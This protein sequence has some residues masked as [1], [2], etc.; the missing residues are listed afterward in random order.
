MIRHVLFDLDNTLYSAS[1]GLDDFYFQRVWE[2]AASWLKL[3]PEEVKQIWTEGYTR[4]GTTIGW[5]KSERGFNDIEEYYAWVH[6]EHE[7]DCLL[8]DP[9]LRAFLESLPYPS[10][11][12]TNS[13]RFHADRILKKLELEGVFCQII[14]IEDTGYYG[15]PEAAA[16][17]HALDALGLKPEEVLFIDDTPRYVQGYLAMGGRGLLIDE[18]DKHGNFPHERIKTLKEIERFL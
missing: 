13:P 2:F 6:P 7:A 4:H 15:K 18:N 14:S 3:P 11:I 9:Q 8:P 16:Y 12:L 5:L 17:Q 10:S 1:W